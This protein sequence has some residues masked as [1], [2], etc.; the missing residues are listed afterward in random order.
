MTAY[1]DG[2]STGKSG[3]LC[4]PKHIIV[5]LAQPILNLTSLPVSSHHLDD[6]PI[7]VIVKIYRCIILLN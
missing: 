5:Y 3:Q 7:V 4:F 2:L 6:D 1:A